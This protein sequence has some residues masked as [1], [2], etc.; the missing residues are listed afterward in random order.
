MLSVA[1]LIW[2][3][4]NSPR[5]SG[6]LDRCR[7]SRTRTR[8]AAVRRTGIAIA[9]AG[10]GA[11]DIRPSSSDHS[12]TVRGGRCN[13]RPARGLPSGSSTRWRDLFHFRYSWSSSCRRSPTI[14]WSI[15]NVIRCTSKYT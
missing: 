7:A 8:A 4:V 13:F 1:Y 2:R 5:G 6:G 10:D 14:R 15:Y 12:M 3:V 9:K 11:A